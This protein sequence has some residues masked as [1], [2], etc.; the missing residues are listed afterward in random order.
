[1]QSQCGAKTLFIMKKKIKG[2]FLFLVVCLCCGVLSSCQ[3]EDKT[4]TCIE[5]GV[6]GT[7]SPSD[8]GVKTC[9]DLNKII[10]GVGQSDTYCW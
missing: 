1:M 9:D 3:K 5:Y 8:Y 10:K 2:L 7:V 6:K 4:C